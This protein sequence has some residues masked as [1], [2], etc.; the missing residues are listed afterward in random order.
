MDSFGIGA[1]YDAIQFGDQGADTLGHIHEHCAQHACDV[2]ELRS[3]L[4]K[5][6]HLF[7]LGLYHAHLS[8]T[9]KRLTGIDYTIEPQ[10]LFGYAVEQSFGK[11]TPSGHWEIA[12]VPVLFDWGYFPSK[13]DCFPDVLLQSLISKANLPGVLGNCHASGTEIIERLGEEHIKTGKPIVYT[14]AD[15]VFQIA[16]HEESFGLERLYEVCQIARELVNEYQVGRVIARPFIGQ[17]GRFIR[18][19]NRKDLSIPPP[20]PTLLDQL[21]NAGG[22]VLA[23]GK[24]ADIFAHQGISH[25][26]KAHGNHELFLK[27]L[28]ILEK[29]EQQQLIFTNFVDFDSL[30]GHRRNIAGYANALE[31]FDAQIPSLLKLLQPDDLVIFTADH[32]CDPTFPGSDHTREHIPII[33]YSPSLKPRFIGRRDSFADIGQTAAT[34]LGMDP[35]KKGVSFL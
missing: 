15:S 3:G 10:G 9:G 34:W 6:P 4:L 19:A 20:E 31:E 11:D 12:G 32:G 16:A 33:A 13:T 18:T 8:S 1:S 23:I 24:T 27:T 28:Q 35:L 29:K 30:Y 14:S 26:I 7:N 2:K 5:L 25:E 17:P 21:L 22:E